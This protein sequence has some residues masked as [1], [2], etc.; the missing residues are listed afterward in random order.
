MKKVYELGPNIRTMIN[1]M[2]TKL[3]IGSKILSVNGFFNEMNY[4]EERK[5]EE[6]LK[7]FEKPEKKEIINQQLPY[8]ELITGL[9]IICG[10]IVYKKDKIIE[11]KKK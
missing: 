3:I 11:L 6:L 4:T 1:N 8:W 10:M 9:C 7:Y 5:K 2:S